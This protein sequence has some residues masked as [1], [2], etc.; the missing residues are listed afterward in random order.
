MFFLCITFRGNLSNLYPDIGS[1]FCFNFPPLKCLPCWFLY[2][3]LFKTSG[4][5]TFRTYIGEHYPKKKKKKKTMEKLACGSGKFR[6]GVSQVPE[7]TEPLPATTTFKE[8]GWR[9]FRLRNLRLVVLITTIQWANVFLI[10]VSD[11]WGIWLCRR[12]TV[13]FTWDSQE[14]TKWN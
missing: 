5:Q 7:T 2:I 14:V 4:Y 12:S 11:K 1:T 8:S 10:W 13:Y 6:C 9:K 3:S